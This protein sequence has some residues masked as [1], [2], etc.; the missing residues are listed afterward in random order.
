MARGVWGFDPKAR[1]D[2]AEKQRII[3]ACEAHIAE[4]L[5]PRFLPEI[6]ETE[7]NYPVGISGKW[8]GRHYR[9]L[10]RYRSGYADNKGEEFDVPFARLEWAGRDRFDISYYRH[11][12]KWFP[13]QRGLTLEKALAKI[14]QGEFGPF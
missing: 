4:V 1:P 2:P 11:T 12:E 3:A 14:G 9:F 10:T 13:L 7:F 8:H 5:M 6:R